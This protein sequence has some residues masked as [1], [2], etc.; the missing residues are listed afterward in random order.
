MSTI[1]EFEL[2]AQEAAGC[3]KCPLSEGRTNVVFGAGSPQADVMFIGEAPGFHEDQQ[4][5]PFVGR[6]GN[7][8]TKLCGEIG[9]EREDVYIANILKCRPPENRDP[10]PSEIETCTPYL[11]RQIDLIQPIVVVTLGNFATKYL[12]QT[13][14]GITTI[15]GRRFRWR[16][17]TLIPT[18][19][20][21]AALRGGATR[22]A[23]MREDFQ[24]ILRTIEHV[25][26]AKHEAAFSDV[27]D[28]LTPQPI[29]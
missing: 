13:T 26:T 22:L 14:A 25:R 9:I 1:S 28:D 8:L 3:V 27:S 17:A 4:G 18:L 10:L 23:E 29:S 21:A 19:H 11:D 20:P 12:L 16:D 5:L 7:L 2:L 24:T 6:S 15:R